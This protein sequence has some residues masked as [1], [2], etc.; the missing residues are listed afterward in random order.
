MQACVDLY[1]ADG[2][3]MV[4]GIGIIFSET[5]ADEVARFGYVPEFWEPF[6]GPGSQWRHIK[7]F[8][9]I[10]LQT[11]MWKNG[12]DFVLHAPGQDCILASDPLL[13]IVPCDSAGNWR[14]KQ[15]TAFALPDASLPESIRGSAVGGGG[16]NPYQT[17]LFR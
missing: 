3:G 2:Y 11:T 17:E 1:V 4:P 5:I 9:A 10:Y 15:L 12:M 8:H 14:M 7:E 6:L 13:P 16:V